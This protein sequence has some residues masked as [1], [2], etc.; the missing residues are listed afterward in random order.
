MDDQTD[1]Q[2]PDIGDELAEHGG[3]LK[4]AM[5]GRDAEHRNLL[6]RLENNAGIELNMK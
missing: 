5:H 3:K 1:K 6:D 4:T 2:S